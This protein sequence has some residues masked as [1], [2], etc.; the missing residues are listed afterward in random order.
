VNALPDASTCPA[1][2]Y[3]PD[4]RVR[5]IATGRLGVVRCYLVARRV[6]IVSPD[7]H[8]PLIV[9]AEALWEWEVDPCVVETAPLSVAL[10]HF[11]S[12]WRRER[13]SW[14]GQYNAGARV[15]AGDVEPVSPYSFLAADTGRPEAEIR[16]VRNPNRYPLTELRTADA[17]VG[18]L[19]G[20]AATFF[21][22]GT[23]E[24]APNPR[25]TSPA[26]AECCGGS[27]QFTGSAV[28]PR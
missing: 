1:R 4:D 20:E 12:E 15:A 19:G 21:Y 24:I 18:S 23:L 8:G 16:K 22:D 2:A 5:E 17:L 7:D 10:A 28:T 25:S 9:A 13:P 11:V 27:G 14:R 3:Q 26:R 6:L